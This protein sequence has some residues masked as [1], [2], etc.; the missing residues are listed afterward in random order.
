[1]DATLIVVAGICV[2]P[3]VIVAYVLS[4][5][6]RRLADQNRELLKANLALSEKPPAVAQAANME[7][8]ERARIGAVQAQ[9]QAKSGERRMVGA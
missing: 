7:I 6:N 9:A 3:I 5:S 8:T 1:M 2:I 4:A